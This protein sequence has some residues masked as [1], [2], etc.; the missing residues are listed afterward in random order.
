MDCA[1]LF[2]DKNFVNHLISFLIHNQSTR[3]QPPYFQGRASSI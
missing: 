2:L 1:L 3:K